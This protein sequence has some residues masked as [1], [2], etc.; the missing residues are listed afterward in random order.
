MRDQ[1]TTGGI[2]VKKRLGEIE[3]QHDLR[4][5]QRTHSRHRAEQ[6]I[7]SGLRGIDGIALNIKAIHL[8]PVKKP[9]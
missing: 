4:L 6:R 3:E 5:G 9:T 8:G 7:D 2:A 1:R